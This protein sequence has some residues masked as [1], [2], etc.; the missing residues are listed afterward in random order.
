MCIIIISLV[1]FTFHTSRRF[2]DL[3]LYNLLIKNS[4][5][6]FDFW[7]GSA[8]GKR[9]EIKMHGE[10]AMCWAWCWTLNMHYLV[11][12]LP[13]A[14]KVGIII[15]PDRWRNWCSQNEKKMPEVI[16]PR[17]RAPF[18]EELL[19]K[20]K[21]SYIFWHEIFSIIYVYIHNTHRHLYKTWIFCI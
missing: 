2:G 8:V 17:L 1:H 12:S 9:E 20:K 15:S 19:Q 7:L 16:K 3:I 4:S 13:H 18:S 5:L 21:L 10:N 6:K 14:F 11:Q